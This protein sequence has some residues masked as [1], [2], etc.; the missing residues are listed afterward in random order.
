MAGVLFRV[1]AGPDVGLGHLQRC[2]SLGSA[3]R[4]RGIECV[5]VTNHATLSAERIAAFGFER[6]GVR[7]GRSWGPEDLEQTRAAADEREWRTVVVD[8]G[9][10]GPEYLQS[11]REAGLSVCALE[12]LALFPF[13]CQLVV[14]GDAHAGRLRY[15]SS[16]GDTR[17]LL[18]P[19]YSVLRPE[20]WE[21]PERPVRP[22]VSRILI[23]LGG[24]DPYNF[25][26]SLLH[27]IGELPVPLEMTAVI[28][29]YFECHEELQAVV[30]SLPSAVRLVAAPTSVRSFM[31]EAD[32]AVSAAGQT[33]YELARVG[34]PAVSFSMGSDQ[35]EQ[36]EAI[37]RAGCARSV[38]DARQGD[39]CARIR[40]ALTGLLSDAPLRSAMAKAGRRLVDGQGAHRVAEAVMAMAEG[41]RVEADLP[42]RGWV[43]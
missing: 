32:L 23:S 3:L 27:M 11:L 12:D 40:E 22:K 4:R 41:Q 8:S 38:G 9:C 43:S 28:G 18:G 20:F 31:E 14:N 13:P 29:P 37:A 30:Q 21:V 26:P 42:K 35:S 15:L 33:L 25:M 6:E 17:F 7:A 36:L 10:K 19:E 24:A 16:S 39:L 2:L 5:F 1:D 34:C